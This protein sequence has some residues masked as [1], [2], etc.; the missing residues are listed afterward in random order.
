MITS[1]AS[2]SAASLASRAS[3]SF[4]DGGRGG[5]FAR[6]SVGARTLRV[7]CVSVDVVLVREETGFN[8]R[9]EIDEIWDTSDELEPLLLCS[10]CADGLRVGRAGDCSEPLRVGRGGG[11]SRPGKVGG[12]L[13]IDSV[14][15]VRR[16]RLGASCFCGRGGI[17]GL[18]KEAVLFAFEVRTRDGSLPAPGG[19]GG[20]RFVE[21]GGVVKFFCLFK[22]AIRSASEL[23]FGSSTSAILKVAGWRIARCCLNS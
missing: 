12:V 13:T 14:V 10:G 21:G 11:A 6:S 9:F 8:D 2:L 15:L 20:G 18:C 22:A 16:G 17:L 1:V 4:R 23:N 3:L 7:G 19:G 5:N